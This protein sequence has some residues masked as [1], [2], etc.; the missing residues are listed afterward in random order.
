MLRILSMASAVA[1]L[2][3]FGVPSVNAMGAAAS[4][5]TTLHGSAPGWAKQGNLVGAADPAGKVGFRV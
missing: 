2:L 4:G 3:V 1:A 5:R